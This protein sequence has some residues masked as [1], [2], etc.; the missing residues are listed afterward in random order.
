MRHRILA[1]SGRF[2]IV[3][4]PRGGTELS[5]QPL[6]AKAIVAVPLSAAG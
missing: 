3:A 5:A 4:A 6:A 2:D 1:L